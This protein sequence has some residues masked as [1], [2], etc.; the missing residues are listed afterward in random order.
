MTI[1]KSA[2]D[3]GF[4]I[5][6]DQLSLL[7]LIPDEQLGKSIKLLLEN[8][9]ELPE[10]DDLAYEMIATN[11][12]R[13]REQSIKARQS[14]LKGGNPTLKGGDNGTVKLQDKK[15]QDKNKQEKNNIIPSLQEVIDYCNERNNGVDANTWYD[16]YS[17]KGWVIGKSPMKDWKAAVRTWERKNKQVVRQNTMTPS[18]EIFH[19]N[20]NHLQSLFDGGED[21]E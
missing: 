17:S 14:G 1:R 19:H 8:F 10:K 9:D 6:K 2:T 5:F 12:R 20:F 13:Y 4:I 3:N 18:E 15:R 7:K 21:V 11:V 16:F